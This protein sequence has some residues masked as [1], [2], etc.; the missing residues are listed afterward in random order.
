MVAAASSM[1]LMSLFLFVDHAG[2]DAV[3]NRPDILQFEGGNAKVELPAVATASFVK[4]DMIDMSPDVF[5]SISQSFT[6]E[7]YNN[8]RRGMAFSAFYFC[9][10]FTTE[11]FWVQRSLDKLVVHF[12]NIPDMSMGTFFSL[13]PAVDALGA[14]LKRVSSTGEESDFVVSSGSRPMDSASKQAACIRGHQ[15]FSDG[16][17]VPT[18][19]TYSPLSFGRFVPGAFIRVSTWHALWISL[20]ALRR[21]AAH[22]SMVS[23]LAKTVFFP[24][25]WLSL[26][27]NVLFYFLPFLALYFS[28][29]SAPTVANLAFSGMAL[30][31]LASYAP[32]QRA[33]IILVFLCFATS[34][35]AVTCPTCFDQ[36]EG[37]QGG[38]DCPFLTGAAANATFIAG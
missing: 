35:E 33:V 1:L 32:H 7:L 37:C 29:L 3:A 11:N 38:G 16:Y 20:K 4:T 14:V 10:S 6:A 25:L 21:N 30:Q 24:S 27:V 2:R 17:E 9:R 13:E 36:L 31:S 18:Q 15:S 5:Q 23:R 34:V 19:F 12:R 28:V 8:V 22:L 26:L